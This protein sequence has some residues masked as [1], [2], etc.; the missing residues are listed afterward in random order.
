MMQS[1]FYVLVCCFVL[2]TTFNTTGHAEPL[3][4]DRAVT[5]ALRHNPGL[6]SFSEEIKAV[7]AAR[8]DMVLPDNPD[9]FIEHE[10]IPLG[11]SVSEYGEKKIGISQIIELPWMYYYRGKSNT[12][13]SHAAEA[14][15]QSLKKDITVKVRKAFYRVLLLQNQM[16]LY[17]GIVDL[18]ENLYRTAK[19]KVDAGETTAYESLRAKVD[20]AEAENRY[21]EVS[22]NHTYSLYALRQLLGRGKDDTLEITG[23]MAFE[24]V[25]IDIDRLKVQSLKSHPSLKQALYH[26]EQRSVEKTLSK[27]S[28]VPALSVS[29]FAMDMR[30]E[31]SSAWGGEIGFSLPIWGLWKER[32]SL[33]AADHRLQAA[34]W[35]VESQKRSVLADVEQAANRLIVA[36]D[37]LVKYR[38]DVLGEVDEMVRIAEKSYAEGEMSYLEMT[39][40]LR[41]MQR[42]KAG[43][44]EGLYDYLAAA[45]DL[46]Q[47][48]GMSIHGIS[49]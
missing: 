33:K 37:H 38:D 23:E 46:E 5:E 17:S 20:L 8:W 28:F 14:G 48:V 24:P 4:I 18:T 40:A 3:T 2:L 39:E 11:S 30:E 12:M 21:L 45:A 35:Q 26:V 32:G 13:E 41:T 1:L 27:L 10:G 31:S 34:G 43:Y 15:Y 9:I 22:T 49:K 6:I 25:D 7:K 36:Q 47:A 44:Y 16:K 29:Y 42:A 19:I